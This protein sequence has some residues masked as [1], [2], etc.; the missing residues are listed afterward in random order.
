MVLRARSQVFGF[1]TTSFGGLWE[2]SGRSPGVP[3]KT[4]GGFRPT[5]KRRGKSVVLRGRCFLLRANLWFGE[6]GVYL[7]RLQDSF[8]E[9]SQR[10]LGGRPH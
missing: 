2:I 6:I 4:L 7:L 10:P 9:I 8:A 5:S 1:Q 3:W